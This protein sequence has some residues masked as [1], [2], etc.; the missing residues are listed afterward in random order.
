MVPTPKFLAIRNNKFSKLPKNLERVASYYTLSILPSLPPQG[1][2]CENET[3]C[4]T[5]SIDMSNIVK[6][7]KNYSHGADVMIQPA[8]VLFDTT[9][10]VRASFY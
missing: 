1:C 6:N 2:N 9:F 10:N 8:R 7:S 4:V 3:L 5:Y